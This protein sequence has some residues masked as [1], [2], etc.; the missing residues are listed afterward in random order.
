VTAAF[1]PDPRNIS[2]AGD[3]GSD[4]AGNVGNI[5]V[6]SEEDQKEEGHED[7]P[8]QV[9]PV[10]G[11]FPRG[12]ES[13]MTSESL[14]EPGSESGQLPSPFRV[15]PASVAPSGSASAPA[16][17]WQTDPARA[18][19]SGDGASSS[20][21]RGGTSQ[22]R[23]RWLGRVPYQEALDLQHFLFD[24]RVRGEG[25]DYLLLLEHPHTYTLGRRAKP[26]HLLRSPEEFSELGA[27]VLQANRGGDVTYHGPGQLVIYPI[28][29]L[30]QKG[31]PD[32]VAHV[33]SLEE[34]A[35]RVLAHFGLEGWREEGLSGVWTSKGKVAQVG[36]RITRGVSMHGLAINLFPDLS[37]FQHIVPCGITGRRVTSMACLLDARADSEASARTPTFFPSQKDP[38]K[39]PGQDFDTHSARLS[40]R[41]TMRQ[42]VES[43]LVH[44]PQVFAREFSFA[45]ESWPRKRKTAHPTPSGVRRIPVTSLRAE[46]VATGPD[47]RSQARARPV[48]LRRRANLAEP[49]FIRLK[50][51]M[52]QL[53]LHTVCEEASCPNIYE[54][55]SEQTATFMLLGK[56]CTRSCGFCD[57]DTGKPPVSEK[58]PQE[59][60]RVADAVARLGL[61]HVV[62][63]SVARDDLPDG[64]AA[65]FARSIEEVCTQSPTCTIEVLVPDFKGDADAAALVFAAAP[66][67][68]NHNLETPARLQRLTR[69]QAGYARSLALLGRAKAAGLVTK[70]GIICGMGE[71]F[72]ET[73]EAMRD[74]R[75]VGVDILTL[76]Q[77]LRPSA[78]HLP[79]DRWLPPGEFADLRALGDDIGFG[80]VEAGPLVRSSYHAK[81]AVEQ[82]VPS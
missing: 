47:V 20:P 6:F 24:M 54:C 49:G 32:V 35:L 21:A 72:E 38:D 18:Q 66:D 70:S 75:A 7:I 69:P 73:A 80:H 59:P 10:L 4:T 43:V 51:L 65:I 34:L 58:D 2:F 57:V 37:Y 50:A 33:R 62:L 3:V 44:A 27:T 42:A 1:S 48:W 8:P 9:G 15:P 64:G 23:A 46:A 14:S 39:G 81:S 31:H 82:V 25:A 13:K 29:R 16:L 30:S 60:A 36:C 19:V 61:H 67:V 53:D 45:G 26:A 71:T 52:R 76:G 68:F 11:C 17:P 79:V 78:H 22:A 56:V 12:Q 5:L 41:L 28:F 55:W 40:S 74:L 63:T 77:Y